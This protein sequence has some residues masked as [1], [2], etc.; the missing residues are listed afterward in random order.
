[1]DRFANILFDLG[2]ELLT[3]LYPDENR[4]CQINYE[5]KLQIQ[6]QFDESKDQIFIGVF[7]ADV[8]PGKYREKLL[9]ASL[10]YNEKYPR[11]GTMGYSE[12]NNQLTLFHYLPAAEITSS[13]L[14]QVFQDF[15]Q[16]ALEWKEA[17][18]GGKALPIDPPKN[19]GGSLFGLHP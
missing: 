10:V 15:A 16:T 17:I 12:R 6:I 5:E 11:I 7:L 1:M 9:R 3:D 4:I 8:P 13:Q 2:K 18:E 14:A 19:Q